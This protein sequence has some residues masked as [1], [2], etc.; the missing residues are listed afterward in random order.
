VSVSRK[1]QKAAAV[2]AAFC[3]IANIHSTAVR[4]LIAGTALSVVVA[5]RHRCRH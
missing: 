4:N 3:L 2:A 1:K 5:G